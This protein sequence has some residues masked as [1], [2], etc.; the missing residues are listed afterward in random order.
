MRDW[1]ISRLWSTA[2]VTKMEGVRGLTLSLELWH[3]LSRHTFW[4]AICEQYRKKIL[5]ILKLK[6]MEL[7]QN[8]K[9]PT[10]QYFFEIFFFVSQKMENFKSFKIWIRHS[11]SYLDFVREMWQ[12]KWWF[13]VCYLLFLQRKVTTQFICWVFFH[14]G[15]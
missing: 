13:V 11:P 10:W 4:K 5:R 15:F 3:L 14:F 1:C 6:G 8:I 12:S 7:E 9:Y 2:K